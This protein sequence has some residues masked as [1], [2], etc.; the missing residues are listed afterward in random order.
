MNLLYPRRIFPQKTPVTHRTVF[1]TTQTR[2]IMYCIQIYGALGK[3][4][5]LVFLADARARYI[6]II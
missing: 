1:L 6:R 4:D 2:F 3:A 5:Y